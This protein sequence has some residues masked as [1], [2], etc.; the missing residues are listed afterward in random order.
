M[1]DR[2]AGYRDI[3]R[4][5]IDE[6]IV[7]ST[8]FSF[9]IPLA[10]GQPPAIVDAR[11]SSAKGTT[12][13]FCR[14]PRGDNSFA[15]SKPFPLAHS[16]GRPYLYYFPGSAL[17]SGI[18][19]LSYNTRFGNTGHGMDNFKKHCLLKRCRWVL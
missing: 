12:C 15:N 10:A 11:I 9:T 14:L 16:A 2:T 3:L 8:L 19:I 17:D 4:V 7:L 6:C 18:N 13:L 5:I 1:A